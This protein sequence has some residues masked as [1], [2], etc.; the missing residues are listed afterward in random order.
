MLALF[1]RLR[2]TGKIAF[3]V[4]QHMAHEAHA[5]LTVRL[6]GRHATM[7]VVLG[8]HGLELA[9]DTI[10]VIPAGRDG[11]VE[12]GH[13]V[14]GI[15]GAENLSTPSVNVLF[16][17]L[18]DQFGPQAVG[19][20]LSGAGS[21]GRTGCARIKARGG[22]VLV[23]DPDE[24]RFSGMPEAAIQARA[25]T[26]TLT[27]ERI[28]QALMEMFPGPGATP[29]AVQIVGAQV[30]QAEREE[31]DRLLP[32]VMQQTGVDFGRYKEETLLRRLEK[33][34]SKLALPRAEDYLAYVRRQPGELSILQHHFLVS[35]SS[36]FRDRASFA[37][38]QGALRDF[39]AHRPDLSTLRVWVPGCASGEEAWSLAILIRETIGAGLGPRDVRLLGTDLNRAA[40]DVADRGL[41][42]R[43]GFREMET[44]MLARYFTEH[45]H[46]LEVNPALR[47]MVEFR[48]ADVLAGPPV[49]GLALVSC[50]NLLIYLKQ[51]L[52]DR[53]LASIHSALV[54]H[55]LLFLGQAEGLGFASVSLFAP[56]D[57]QHRIFRKRGVGSR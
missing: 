51:P 23:Q 48:E 34:K 20:I 41:Y 1:A 57:F 43:S 5:E 27:A 16:N 30:S 54:P 22:S 4:A 14:L 46:H 7:P 32:L 18:A 47:E 55:G 44:D 15:P 24:A 25:V 8:A 53:L 19:I 13:L 26:R 21:D 38:L 2:P 42:R 35:V 50:R 39:L 11:L 45:G 37:V 9:V 28:G 56:V 10:H 3:V 40:L 33:R 49:D 12:D 29:P 31:L 52:Q 6:L 36:F 17:S